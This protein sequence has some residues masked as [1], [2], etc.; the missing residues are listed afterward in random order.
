MS[1]EPVGL[2]PDD[3]EI[4]K[5]LTPHAQDCYLDACRK[6]LIKQ[7]ARAFILTQIPPLETVPVN[8]ITLYFWLSRFITMGEVQDSELLMIFQTSTD[9][10]AKNARPKR[11]A[12]PREIVA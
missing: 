2:N 5:A 11:N 10:E 1:S 4:I 7:E 6:S 8:A 3:A 12:T 9:R